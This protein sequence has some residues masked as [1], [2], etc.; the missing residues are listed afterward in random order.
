MEFERFLACWRR[1]GSPKK[2][3][4]QPRTGERGQPEFFSYPAGLGGSGFR[5]VSSS[6]GGEGPKMAETGVFGGNRAVIRGF[7]D[8]QT[9][10]PSRQT[11]FPSLPTASAGLPAALASRPTGFPGRESALAG[12]PM[13][14]AGPP[15]GGASGR[16]RELL[17]IRRSAD[18]LVGVFLRCPCAAAPNPDNSHFGPKAQ[19]TQCL[20][21]FFAESKKRGFRQCVE[22]RG[23]WESAQNPRQC[24]CLLVLECIKCEICGLR[25]A[26]IRGWLMPRPNVAP[27]L[28]L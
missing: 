6:R 28:P 22:N 5:R 19:N 17:G 9:A 15:S 12:L 13:A 8:L 27:T 26:G 20:L 25:A 11:G 3:G 10:F 7:A 24:W 14:F 1:E 21:A 2:G 4:E 23:A 16:I 18:I